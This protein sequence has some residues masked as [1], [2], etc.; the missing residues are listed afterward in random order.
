[1]CTTSNVFY[2]HRHQTGEGSVGSGSSSGG[3]G[4]GGG[5]GAGAGMKGS[6]RQRS[7]GA[8]AR[9][10]E[11]IDETNPHPSTAEPD[12][13]LPSIHPPTDDEGVFINT[14]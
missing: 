9:N 10:S 2:T 7:P 8:M 3:G 5:G 14:L 4:G 11:T 6:G 13:F 12:D 1:M